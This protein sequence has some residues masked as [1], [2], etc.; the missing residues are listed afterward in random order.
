M[1][2]LHP[3]IMPRDT[4]RRYWL[5]KT[6]PGCFSYEDLLACQ[7]QTAYWDGVRNYQAR[8]FLRDDVRV[9][10]GVLFYYSNAEPSGVVGTATVVRAGY[11]DHTA[12]DPAEEHYDPKSTRE[13]PIW[14][15]VDIKAGERFRNFLALG[16]LRHVPALEKMELLRKGSRLS[17]MPVSASEWKTVC[18]MGAG[19]RVR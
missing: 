2:R 11:P 17:V 1:R 12:L 13:N 4:D 15:M 8:N 5:L 3:I 14:Y 9:G 18:A 19:K 6:E 16:D 7:D 10:D